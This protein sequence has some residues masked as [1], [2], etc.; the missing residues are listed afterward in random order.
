MMVHFIGAGPGDPDLITVKGRDLIA[1]C[2]VC[3]Y[4]G[5]LVP[6]ALLAHAPAGARRVDT[7]GLTLDEIVGEMSAAHSRGDD[8]ARLHSGDLAVFSAVGEQTRRLDALGIPWT[9]TPGV[10]A[11]AAAAA[12][13]GRELTLPGVAQTVILTRPGAR[14][15]AMPDGESL[16][17]LAAHGTTLVL[18]LTVGAA[19]RIAD[20]LLPAYGPDCPVAVVAYATQPQ[21]TVVRT[22]LADLVAAVEEH[23]VGRN[24]MFIFGPALAAEGFHDSHL[25]SAARVRPPS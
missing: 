18:H 21:E 25:Y 13:I 15:T 17:E 6:E 19:G 22:R 12:A 8:V 2:P 3:L 24:A 16:A 1:S 20:A 23:G 14:A 10:P 11:V 7:Q 4:A 5:S 9:M